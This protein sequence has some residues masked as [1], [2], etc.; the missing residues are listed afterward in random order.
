MKGGELRRDRRRI[1][2]E[3]IDRERGKFQSTS[4]R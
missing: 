3:G 2:K 1:R 4:S